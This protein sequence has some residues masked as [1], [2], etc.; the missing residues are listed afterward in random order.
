MLFWLIAPD[1]R[2]LLFLVWSHSL[3]HTQACLASLFCHTLASFFHSRNLYQDTETLTYASPATCI[4]APVNTSD[5]SSKPLLVVEAHLVPPSFNYRHNPP[6][7]SFFTRVCNHT[8]NP[9]F[10]R[11]T[12]ERLQSRP[13]EL[14]P[15]PLDVNR[16][17]NTRLPRQL[18][19][20]HVQQ[21][22]SHTG[23]ICV[24]ACCSELLWLAV[25]VTSLAFGGGAGI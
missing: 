25:G 13:R 10:M 17:P 6:F 16:F 20:N 2:P 4:L 1:D 11:R 8:L 15:L 14:V 23:R 9:F 12:Y 21:S 5:A 3:L 18:R 7:V 24:H 22:T 19:R